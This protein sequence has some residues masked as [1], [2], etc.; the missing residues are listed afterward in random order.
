MI[1]LPACRRRRSL[2]LDYNE[3]NFTNNNTINSYDRMVCRPEIAIKEKQ[4]WTKQIKY[5]QGLS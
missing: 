2:I 5:Q 4:K 1:L 3:N